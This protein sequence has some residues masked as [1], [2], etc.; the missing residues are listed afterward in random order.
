M[1]DDDDVIG[2]MKR[3]AFG[4][5]ADRG[6]TRITGSGVSKTE[7]TSIDALAD[8]S[9]VNSITSPWTDNRAMITGMF[10]QIFNQSL[11]CPGHGTPQCCA[12]PAGMICYPHWTE[13]EAPEWYA[14]EINKYLTLVDQRLRDVTSI[15]A[16]LAADE[17]F[18]LGCLFTEALIKFRW[19]RLAKQGQKSADGA[20]LGGNIRRSGNRKRLSVEETV[21]AVD[22]HLNDG[23]TKTRAYGRVA[24]QQ[25]VSEQS[26]AKEYRGAKKKSGR[27][28]QLPLGQSPS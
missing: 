18:E 11:Q 20:Q 6:E 27:S 22:G 24:R 8:P 10:G 19:D 23:A 17:A 15:T 3:E 25:G 16:G 5:L 2:Q 1:A 13:R 21:A 4:K 28:G 14:R 12:A 9:L 7:T 26:I